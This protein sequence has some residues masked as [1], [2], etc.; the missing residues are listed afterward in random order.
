M[1]H[2]G[3]LGALLQFLTGTGPESEAGSS[4]ATETDAEREADECRDSPEQI[5][6]CEERLR[7][8]LHVFAD[9][10]LSPE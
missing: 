4:G 6:Q 5:A 7:L 8:F 2:S 9:M 10:P 1:N 3:V